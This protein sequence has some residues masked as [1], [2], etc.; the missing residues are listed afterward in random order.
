MDKA[1]ARSD[2]HHGNLAETLVQ[3]AT[4]L[5]ERQGAD[6]NLSDASKLAGVSKGAPYRHFANKDELLAVVVQR[7]FERLTEV[8]RDAISQHEPGSD[9]AISALGL[10]YIKF[11]TDEPQIFR[12]MFSHGAGR[13]D[14]QAGSVIPSG[15]GVLLNQVSVRTGYTDQA[16]LVE[17]ARPLW[18]LVHGASMLT[19]DNNYQ[20]VD[21][22]GDTEQMIRG[23]TAL[24]LA[25]YN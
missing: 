7:G 23:A 12:L 5:V 19:I 8:T 15:F 16:Q 22:D 6:F 11:A 10:A 24:I 4:T 2:Y 25:P 3:A 13:D 21:P 18:T 9:E 14:D 1:K 20:R 17:I